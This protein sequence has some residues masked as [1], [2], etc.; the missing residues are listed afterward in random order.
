MLTNDEMKAAIELAKDKGFIDESCRD[1]DDEQYMPCNSECD[2]CPASDTCLQLSNN[3]N[4]ETFVKN[5]KKLMEVEDVPTKSEQLSDILNELLKQLEKD[6]PEEAHYVA[7]EL[8][9]K[10]LRLMASNTIDKNRVDTIIDTY[11]NIDKWYA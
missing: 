9:V 10:A 1:I 3:Q 4:Y 2:N 11:Y 8:I 7:D 5:Y 6:C